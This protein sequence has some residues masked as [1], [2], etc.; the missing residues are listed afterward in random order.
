MESALF[1]CAHCGGEVVES[2]GENRTYS[3]RR[4][5]ALPIPAD[6]KIPTCGACGEQ[7]FTVALAERLEEILDPAHR[8]MW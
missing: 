7:Y 1:R 4:G 5:M 2:G 6:F 3:F 8:Q